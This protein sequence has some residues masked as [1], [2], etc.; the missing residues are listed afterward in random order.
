MGTEPAG[1]CP[2]RGAGWD[3]S[4]RLFVRQWDLWDLFYLFIL[5]L[6]L[7]REILGHFVHMLTIQVWI[8]ADV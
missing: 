6:L 3:L 1:D 7:M 2:G 8:C 5:F 4:M